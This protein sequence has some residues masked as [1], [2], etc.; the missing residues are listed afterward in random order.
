[1]LL[2]TPVHSLID[3][4]LHSRLRAE[5]TNGDGFGV[6]WYGAVPVPGFFHQHRA[7]AWNDQEIGDMPGAW[8]E[9]PEA[10]YG[11]VGQGAEQLLPFIP[12]PREPGRRPEGHAGPMLEN[13]CT[14]PGRT[15]ASATP[16]QT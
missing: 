10:S 6:G 3:Q 9:V 7:A 8:R 16:P 12:K 14:V 2:Y 5:T 4:S 11:V 1:M 13:G 15:T